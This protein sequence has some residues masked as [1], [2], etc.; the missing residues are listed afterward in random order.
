V[1]NLFDQFSDEEKQHLNYLGSMMGRPNTPEEKEIEAI[2]NAVE[3][4]ARS[5]ASPDD[6]K[7]TV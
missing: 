3:K 5:K 1:K 4:S 7:S 6:G 2:L